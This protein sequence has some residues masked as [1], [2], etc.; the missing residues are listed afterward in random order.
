MIP[1]YRVHR[2]FHNDQFFLHKIE[3]KLFATEHGAE[4]DI[5]YRE[6]LDK[7]K[8]LVASSKEW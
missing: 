7:A 4:W 1:I 6:T 5:Y 8:A 3:A 2:D